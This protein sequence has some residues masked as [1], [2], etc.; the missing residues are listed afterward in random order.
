M[1]ALVHSREHG[2]YLPVP[3][4]QRGIRRSSSLYA[5]MHRYASTLLGYYIHKHGK[6]IPNL[7]TKPLILCLSLV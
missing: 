5:S 6:I 4:Y 7:A 2:R 3:S 1:H